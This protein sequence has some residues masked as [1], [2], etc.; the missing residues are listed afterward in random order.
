MMADNFPLLFW[1]GNMPGDD[2]DPENVCL[3]AFRSYF[4]V[5]VGQYHRLISNSN[6][7][8]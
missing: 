2:Y 6:K 7:G 3:G 5:R 4:L 8:H 1:S